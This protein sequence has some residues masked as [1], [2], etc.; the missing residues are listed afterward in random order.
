M[1]SA[2]DSPNVP[3]VY[4]FAESFVYSWELDLSVRP[5]PSHWTSQ[6]G[7]SDAAFK[8]ELTI[9]KVTY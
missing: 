7:S 6:S 9:P 8:C 3:E 5:F 2:A 1:K 4:L